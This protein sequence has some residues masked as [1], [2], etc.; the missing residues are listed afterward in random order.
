MKRYFLHE[1]VWA[2]VQPIS[3]KMVQE[4]SCSFSFSCAHDSN[5]E[6]YNGSTHVFP[7]S[8]E[9][10]QGSGASA[11]QLVVECGH[12]STHSCKFK[13]ANAA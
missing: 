3:A 1:I 6:G 12:H 8:L 11:A 10:G 9:F 4:N 7:F 5:M 13:P 2:V